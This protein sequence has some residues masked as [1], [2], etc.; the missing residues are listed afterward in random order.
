[1]SLYK[2][3]TICQLLTYK[4]NFYSNCFINNY[5]YS[6]APKEMKH[7]AAMAIVKDFPK[8]KSSNG[9]GHVSGN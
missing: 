5:L 8:L 1:M 2:K 6:N 7:A 9:L 3:H 4:T